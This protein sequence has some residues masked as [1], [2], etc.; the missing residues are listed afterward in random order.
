MTNNRTRILDV[1]EKWLNE[2]DTIQ[3]VD[4]QRATVCL[5]HI[6]RLLEDAVLVPMNSSSLMNDD[7]D[8]ERFEVLLSRVLLEDYSEVIYNAFR[9]MVTTADTNYQNACLRVVVIL[10][11]TSREISDLFAEVLPMTELEDFIKEQINHPNEL[12]RARVGFLLGEMLLEE[13]N[14][15]DIPIETILQPRI[16]RIK[17]LR[18]LLQEKNDEL[19]EAMKQVH[20]IAKY[21]SNASIPIP[22]PDSPTPDT[23][24][25]GVDECGT[26]GTALHYLTILNGLLHLT[27]ALI[28]F[29]E[30]LAIAVSESLLKECIEI[31]KLPAVPVQ[32]F[33]M[34]L[35]GNALIHRK[36]AMDFIELDGPSE[37][38]RLID[39]YRNGPI[40]GDFETF[41]SHATF[42]ISSIFKHSSAVD[43]FV[44]PSNAN[45]IVGFMFSLFNN[46]DSLGT[47]LNI[48]EWCAE[49]I[50][51]PLLLRVIHAA[52]FWKK[53]KSICD[54][55]IRMKTNPDRKADSMFFLEHFRSVTVLALKYIVAHMF[56]GY[57]YSKSLFSDMDDL[58]PLSKSFGTLI[59]KN[60]VGQAGTVDIVQALSSSPAV[61][62]IDEA[63]MYALEAYVF[64][65]LIRTGH[66]PKGMT[67]DLFGGDGYSS[68]TSQQFFASALQASSSSSPSASE[69]A[70][71]TANATTVGTSSATVSA[72][73]MSYD[74]L[75][76]FNF[77]VEPIGHYSSQPSAAATASTTATAST[78]IH[79]DVDYDAQ[80]VVSM[81]TKV[82]PEWTIVDAAIR[83]G[84]IPALFHILM[85]ENKDSTTVCMALLCLQLLC[86]DAAAIVE[87]MQ[88]DIAKHFD[89]TTIQHTSE[90][91]M[92]QYKKGLE[93][94][95]YSVSSQERRDPSVMVS[96]LR[97]L[98]AM[99]A[100]P[101]F[102]YNGHDA[103]V[104][105]SF[106]ED[107]L[108]SPYFAATQP[109]HLAEMKKKPLFDTAKK[110]ISSKLAY[111]A[112]ENVQRSVRKAIRAHAGISMLTQM[113][114]YK[115]NVTFSI[116][117]RLETLK[118]LLGLQQD[119]DIR[120]ILVKLRLPMVLENQIQ[121]EKSQ[122]NMYDMNTIPQKLQDRA[123]LQFY[124]DNLVNL[125]RGVAIS[126]GGGGG[127]SGGIG[128]GSGS[129]LDA[130]GLSLLDDAQEHL[131]R[132]T[133]VDHSNVR[134]FFSV[135]R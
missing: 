94:L 23:T 125:L 56:W 3:H 81:V 126:G 36:L 77:Q 29:S 112:L 52:N 10:K 67:L 13:K 106:F 4:F 95:L 59:R 119:D 90:L 96:V 85:L 17:E 33:C 118:I 51:H 44:K 100:A 93:V 102:R 18:L 38:Y 40:K 97:L 70:T 74:P 80:S 127:V 12:L 104:A 65:S 45:Q 91:A 108:K 113:L 116:P 103:S 87:I 7:E 25:W 130:T 39:T 22:E 82:L 42:I 49:A 128:F 88:Y 62:K 2:L 50:H 1:F 8:D 124:T 131:L 57:Q 122:S 86:V 92:F 68:S 66:L 16:P 71:T 99:S 117:I 98:A 53:V 109:T 73:A 31:L 111:N 115:K 19:V 123:L 11:L 43:L 41:S 48:L 107:Y 69:T 76:A 84:I 9:S 24:V 79:A 26:E 63:E 55:L 21:T 83:E 27:A 32:T 37:V 114:Y 134:W 34:I 28:E 54:S 75:T 20:E 110:Q 15:P 6:A 89:A 72:N 46:W 129:S 121:A 133:V 61:I 5:H 35:I 101:Y 64:K 58:K 105:H 132:K 135:C 14:L 78:S 30:A 120:Q 60:Y 47:N